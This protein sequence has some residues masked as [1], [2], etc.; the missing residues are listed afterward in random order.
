MALRRWWCPWVVAGLLCRWMVESWSP[1]LLWW[2]VLWWLLWVAAAYSMVVVAR[3]CEGRR[4]LVPSRCWMVS[5]ATAFG[6]CVWRV[7]W[8]TAFALGWSKALLVE[9]A[10]SHCVD[11]VSRWTLGAVVLLESLTCVVELVVT[12]LV[13]V[14]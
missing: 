9:L 3:L 2:M 13:E 4:V 14:E 1:L 8:T 12:V 7:C 11:G 6:R 10:W 5:F